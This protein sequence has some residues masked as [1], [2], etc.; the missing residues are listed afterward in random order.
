MDEHLVNP[1]RIRSAQTDAGDRG[2]SQGNVAT[3]V[4]KL[5]LAGYLEMHHV[6]NGGG[7]EGGR[8]DNISLK[9]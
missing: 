1:G 9:K 3:S 5:H 8:L 6:R 4:S 2:P 7:G